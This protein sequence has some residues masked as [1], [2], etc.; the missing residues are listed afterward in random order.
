Y[1]VS[2]MNFLE[3]YANSVSPGITSYFQPNYI[4]SDL[5]FQLSLVIAVGLLWAFFS[6][7]LAYFA[8]GNRRN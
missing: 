5:S 8:K 1:L 3:L 2:P 7:L 6:I 4:P